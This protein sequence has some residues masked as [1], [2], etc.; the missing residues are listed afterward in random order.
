MGGK[1]NPYGFVK[2]SLA[3]AAFSKLSE[4]LC[5]FSG[6]LWI[7]CMPPT[8]LPGLVLLLFHLLIEA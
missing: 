2:S 8:V 4:A 3:F 6:T 1:E 7:K 5:W